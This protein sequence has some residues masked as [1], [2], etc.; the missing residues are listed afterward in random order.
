[1]PIEG[2]EELA[3][4]IQQRLPDGVIEAA[5]RAITIGADEVVALMK[6]RVPVKEGALRD[7]IG[8]T[9]GDVPDGSISIGRV[10]G[11]E[12]GQIAA[13]IYAGD[14]TTVVYNSRGV[15]FQNARMQQFGTRGGVP[16]SDYFLG[17]W[18]DKRR[19]VRA[20][21][22]REVNKAIREAYARG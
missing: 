4:L 19:S 16:A 2:V 18:A 11:R 13:T 17:A 22:T 20:R 21:I 12:F 3:R 6:S 14:S 15:G 1:M 7:S 8:W 9:F 10:S 5:R